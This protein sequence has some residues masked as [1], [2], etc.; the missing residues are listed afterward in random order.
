M[1]NISWFSR[2]TWG[3]LLLGMLILI[4]AP[5][6]SKIGLVNFR[7]SFIGLAIGG[8]FAV[9]AAV[10]A[11]FGL[12]RP[13]R[14]QGRLNTLIAFLGGL[15]IAGFLGYMVLSAMGKPPI[16]DISTDLENRPQFVSIAPREYPDGQP[17][18]D[19]Q[20]KALHEVGYKDLKPL[21]VSQGVETVTNTAASVLEAMGLTIADVDAATGRVEATESTFWFGFKD[22]LVVRV[23]TTETGKSLVD[24]RS[25]SRVG[26]SDVG[27]N[28]KRI[29][30]FFANLSSA[31]SKEG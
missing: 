2:I 9:I 4:A 13:L 18:T 5:L 30:T 20:R 25:V 8:A 14:D 15:G 3:A 27:A 11:V 23:T 16:H 28:A 22:D 12:I 26:L 6:L 17:F 1:A 31:L 19:A 21:V 24:A 7:A 10:V 29:E